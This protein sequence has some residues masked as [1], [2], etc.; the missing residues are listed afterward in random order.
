M[1]YDSQH[2]WLQK[3]KKGGARPSSPPTRATAAPRSTGGNPRSDWRSPECRLRGPAAA[4][5]WGRYPLH[6]GIVCGQKPEIRTRTYGYAN[7]RPCR[8][9]Q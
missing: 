6:V 4:G 5:P 1:G 3:G 8:Y 9:S 2:A 7:S